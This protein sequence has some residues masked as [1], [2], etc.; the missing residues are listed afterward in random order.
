[1]VWLLA[2]ACRAA[3][4]FA[5]YA[6]VSPIMTLSVAGLAPKVIWTDLAA[7]MVTVQLLEYCEVPVQAPPQELIAR[8]GLAVKSTEMVTLLLV[9]YSAV[10]MPLPMSIPAGVV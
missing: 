1:M 8:V 5:T 3:A 2:A 9:A 10:M 6:L 7:S 4:M